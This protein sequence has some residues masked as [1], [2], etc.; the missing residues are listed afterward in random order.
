MKSEAIA[1]TSFA[2]GSRRQR[3][4]GFTPRALCGLGTARQ[5]VDGTQSRP[6]RCEERKTTRPSSP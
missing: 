1:T 4:D 6:G 2:L 3:V 5:G